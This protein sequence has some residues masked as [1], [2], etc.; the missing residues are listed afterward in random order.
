[1]KGAT[2][3]PVTG[4]W[5]GARSRR[6][7]IGQILSM[8]FAAV[9]TMMV[10]ACA[11]GPHKPPDEVWRSDGYGWIYSLTGSQLQI[12]EVTEIS[13]LP[14]R[15]LGQIGPPSVKGFTQFG[16]NGIPSQTLR[17]EPNGK[18]ILHLMGTAADVDLIPLPGLPG[19]CTRKASDD[20]RTNFDIFWTTFAE[21]YNSFG[22]KNIDW[23]AV[24]DR[25]RPRVNSNT[26]P[27]ELFGILRAMIEPLGDIHTSITG[28]DD[29]EFSGLRPGTRKLSYRAVR[30]AVGNHLRALGA[31]HFQSFAQD[32]I[33]YAD[34]PDKQ[35][36]LRI[37]AFEDYHGDG[38]SY[39]TDSAELTRALNAVFTTQR[40]AALRHLIIDV[41]LNSGGHD[42]LVLQVAARLTDRPHVAFTKQA[43]NDP[44]DP[45]RH[46]RAQTVT[47]TPADAPRYTGPA[48]LLISDVTISAGETFVQA[49]MGR[50][51]APAR[52]GTTTQGV[53]A[54][55][56]SR[57]LPNG[58]TFNLGNEDYV[59]PDGRNYEGR[60]YHRQSAH[61]CLP[62][63]S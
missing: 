7:R 45:S 22:R 40:V 41:R 9:L 43:R 3:R 17:K 53:F 42:A 2:E 25:Y 33:V 56:M 28:S 48:S 37:T 13:C 29:L 10:P 23:T 1:M 47:V 57:R 5:L 20:P 21:N 19:K 63:R 50:T 6:T 16:R 38:S 39:V 30:T 11:A 15:T 8:A 24:R 60:A 55:N 46:G 31:T 52:I 14:H 44:D 32:K 4:D 58:W 12:Y 34:L 35:G 62:P 26:G 49:M 54:D 51:P 36:Y 61:P 18:A 59:G 27:R